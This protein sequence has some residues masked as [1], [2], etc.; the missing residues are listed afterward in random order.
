MK[1]LLNTLALST[2]LAVAVSC[3]EDD[4]NMVVN[5]KGQAT[6]NMKSSNNSNNTSGRVMAGLEITSATAAV[7][8]VEIESDNETETEV[9]FEG[10]YEVDLL[11]GTSNPEFGMAELAADTYNEIEIEFGTFLDNDASIIVEGNYINDKDE[12]IAFKYMLKKALSIE[13]ESDNGFEVTAG[14]V[15]NIVAEIDFALLFRDIDFELAN[16]NAD[17]LVIVDASLNTYVY[18][19]INQ[20]ISAAFEVEVSED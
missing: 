11:T 12:K 18:N 3:N 2:L 1:Y 19:L 6:F 20:N 8:K 14:A 5:E 7:S 13:I 17:G 4:E 16:A 9:E 10:N 15:K